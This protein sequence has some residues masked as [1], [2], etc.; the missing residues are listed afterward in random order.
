MQNYILAL[1]W[2]GGAYII[3]S[4]ISNLIT[5]R[6]STREAERLGCK[7]APRLPN[8]LPYGID[9][10]REALRADKAQ[11]F[12]QMITGRFDAMGALTFETKVLGIEGHMTADPKNIQAVLATQFHDFE[13]GRTRRGNFYPLLGNGIF[14]NDGKNWEHSRAMMRPQFAR[15][16]VSDLDL[17]EEHVQNMM[18]ALPVVGADGWTA[19][20]DL[21]ILFFRLTLDSAC[22]F[23]FG[24]SP[25]SQLASLDGNSAAASLSDGSR[26]DGAQFAY[27]FDRAN[28][29]LATRT[30]LGDN[31]WLANTADFR[32]CNKACHTF[33][34]YFVNLALNKDL[35][36]SSLEKGTAPTTTT[37]KKDRYVFL[38]A[39]VGQTRD[40][41][42]L[43]SQ[44]LNI[45]LAG[46]DTTAS[47]LGWTFYTLAR[48]PAVYAQ[49][50][51]TVLAAFGPY[52]DPSALT[53]SNLKNCSYL[54]HC[55][56]EVLR[57]YPVVPVNSR[58]AVRDTTLPRGGGPDG[59]SKI[60]VR[61]D[62]QVDYAVH[63]MHHRRD[64]WGED[65][66]AFRP[67]RW[68]GR[69]PGVCSVLSG[70][71]AGWGD[72]EADGWV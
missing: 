12:M 50:R 52:S 20:I 31:Y 17:E 6:R 45:M 63:V 60:F 2:A 24:E 11:Q 33:I 38:D 72:A 47:L 61:K 51:A 5:S 69:K 21:Q 35:K 28:S 66:E 43:R 23:L 48:H 4:F 68:V 65:A 25:G 18:R 22:E 15:D 19:E 54:Q 32:A 16:Q 62:Q 14:T 36:T 1:L 67:E 71:R 53:Y 34:D 39:L 9:R 58:R 13:L 7:P 26:V 44:L 29:W 70:R 27:G 10:I 3:Y 59:R 41:I 49:L 40:P 55:L 64:L 57:L 37:T 46:R 56:H 42:E 8:R 30:R